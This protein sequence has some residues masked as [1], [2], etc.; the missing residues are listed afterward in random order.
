MT[1]AAPE[2]SR[3]ENRALWIDV[4]RWP[5]SGGMLGGVILLTLLAAASAHLEG[6]STV[7]ARETRSYLGGGVS[8]VALMTLGHYAWRA[9]AC[10]FPAE[11]TVPWGKDPADDSSP[12]QR[13]S[14]FIGVLTLSFLPLLLWVSFQ[15]PIGAP[16]WLFWFVTVIASLSGAAIFPLGLAGSV[17]LGSALGA[18]PWRVRRMWKANPAA[19]RIAA[20]SALTFVGM[21]LVSA[22]LADAFVTK[23]KPGDILTASSAGERDMV[24]PV[25]LWSLVALRAGGFYA[26]LVSCRVAGLLVREV[27]EIR[28][29]LA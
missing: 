14:A 27:P 2:V 18:L 8:V 13:L 16:V 29:V 17:A 26:A 22:I 6:G 24:G 5:L 4:V 20:A 7:A 19:A 10:T 21:L 11:R 9:V 25:L 15:A 28:E 23:P 3:E 1:G 12:L